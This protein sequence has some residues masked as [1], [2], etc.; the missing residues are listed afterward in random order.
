MNDEV[1]ESSVLETILTWSFGRPQWQRDALRRI[2]QGTIDAQAIDEILR[3][4][5]KE[6]GKEDDDI[7]FSALEQDQLPVDPGEGEAIRLA[8]IAN[9][10]GVNQLAPRQ[11]LAFNTDGLTVVYGPN[12]S[13]KSGYARILKRA[14]R[15]RHAGE[16][17]PDIYAP[18]PSENATADLAVTKSDGVTQTFQWENNSPPADDLSAITIFDRDCAAVHLQRK[19]EVMFR[20][21]GLDVPDELAG[22]CQELKERL[23]AEK[24]TLERSRNPAFSEPNWRPTSTLGRALSAL[25]H[26]TD[27]EALRP[28]TAFSEE[29]EERLA[30]LHADLSKDPAQAAREQRDISTRL[31]QMLRTLSTIEASHTD[32][33]LGRI[34]N[35]KKA[36]NQARETASL[37][38]TRAF[39]QLDLEGVGSPI[40]IGLW[41][42]ARSYS[43]SIGEDG[44]PF[45]PGEEGTCVLCHQKIDGQT[46]QTMLGFE[47][48]IKADTEESAKEAE[49]KFETEYS[50]FSRKHVS[51]HIVAQSR[52]LLKKLDSECARGVLR[53][54]ATAKYRHHSLDRAISQTN[55]LEL[56]AAIP[57]PREQIQGIVDRSEQYAQSLEAGGDNE[58]RAALENEYAELSD[59]KQADN[60]LAIATAEVER[61][62]QIKLVD[63]CLGDLN[64][65]AITQLG[66]QIAD[67]LITPAMRDQFQEE[68]VSLVST[69]VRVEVVRSGGRFGS[70]Q[71]EVRFLRKP[72]A[73]V[74]DVLSE[75]EQT[76]VALAAYLTELTNASHKSALT[77]D[78][79]VTSLDHR[80]RSRVAKRLVREAATRQVIVFTHDLIFV[81]DLFELATKAETPVGL[82]HLT[83]SPDGVGI[84]NENLPWDKAGVPQRLDE[85]GKAARAARALHDSGDDERYRRAAY[86]I[87]DQLRAAWERALEDIVFAGVLLRHRDYIKPTQL[88]KVTVLEDG[89]VNVFQEGYQKCCDYVDAHDMSRGRDADPPA[90][91]E[92]LEDIGN[93][94]SW[95]QALKAKQR[96]A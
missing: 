28:G 44:I 74:G 47:D 88:M 92:I 79:P 66:N 13:G 45:P 75:G 4:C 77:F 90:P 84:V 30:A 9:V 80:W 40:W 42:A 21:F 24:S 6:H 72:D 48:F 26:E 31:S 62:R 33:E 38:A 82:C 63:D 23:T 7:D 68:I 3:L 81:N 83:R 58:Q 94:E 69:R 8:S 41:E 14:C 32:E 10:V 65:R 96:A 16:I 52:R 19:N 46:A 37:A 39:G 61:L 89:D 50:E 11:T 5:K 35:L 93:L 36:A 51:I 17:M 87:Y 57:F 59:L 20:P 78:D 27:V 49:S 15:S 18:R 22:L 76:C 2:V 25:T 91:E 56:P 34:F 60:L 54:M 95:S 73:P 71:Y 67:E 43:Q 55:E 64:T 12:G 1:Q 86:Q 29:Q 53:F 70:P 85:L